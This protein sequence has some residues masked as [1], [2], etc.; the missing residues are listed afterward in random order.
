MAASSKPKSDTMACPYF[1]PTSRCQEGAW[2][3]P[4]RLPLGAGWEGQC[5]APGHEGVTP[6]AADIREFCNL[7]YA[8]RC[9]RLPKDR[10]ADA[11][12]F[13][14]TRDGGD[15]LTICF[16]H[17][18]GHRPTGYGTLVYDMS[19]SAWKSADSHPR[20]Q[21]MADCFLQSYLMRRTPPAK[22]A[23]AG[24]SS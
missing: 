11:I 24:A 9:S 1:M 18:L 15:Q 23:R 14:V 16:V 10:T 3:H 21:K 17:E 13:A 7:G 22:A 4:S 5:M 2:I 8:S 12:R 20:I 6:N 19:C